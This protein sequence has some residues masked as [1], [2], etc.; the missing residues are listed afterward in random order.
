MKGSACGRCI[1]VCPLTK[2]VTWDGPLYARIG[3]WLGIHAM[4][5]KPILAPLAIWLDDKIGNGNPV[6]A[7]KWW[8]DLEVIGDQCNKPDANNY[9]DTPTVGINRKKLRPEHYIDPK[10]HRISYFP[11]SKVPPPNMEGA[12]PTDRKAGLEIADRAE[13]VKQALARRKNGGPVPEEYRTN[14]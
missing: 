14:W 4:W 12:Y 10:V 6:D 2:D 7:K 3:S 11:A 5:L 1:K 9:C 13:T 8:L